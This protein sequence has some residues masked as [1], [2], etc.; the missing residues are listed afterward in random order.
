MATTNYYIEVFSEQTD[1]RRQH[2]SDAIGREISRLGLHRTISINLMDAPVDN[3]LAVGVYFGNSRIAND[4]QITGIVSRS[5]ALSRV[6]IPVVN[7]L[8]TY[9][10]SVPD[11]LR[12]INGFWWEGEGSSDRLC[13]KLLEELGVE[14]RQRRAFISH[15]RDDGLAAA[16]QLHDYLSH[17][18]FR[19][20]IDRFNIAPGRDVQ[21]EIADQLEDCA[22]LILLETPLAYTSDWV[23]DEV[24]YSLSHQLGMHIISWPDVEIRLPGTQGLPRQHLEASDL[25]AQKGYDIFT[26]TTLERIITA[27][28]AEH[29]RAMI[30]RRRYLLV[31][32]EEAAQDAGR[33]CLPL[34]GWRMVVMDQSSSSIVQVTP[35][36]PTVDDLYALDKVCG[37]YSDAQPGVLIHA[38]RRLPQFRRNVLAWAGEY[39]N[40]SL[41]PE[42]SIGAYW[43]PNVDHV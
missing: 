28:E 2:L 37:C 10:S 9:S 36:L 29:A 31:S 22:M 5:L 24:D 11:C 27:V 3:D 17:N 43:R 34:P 8:A 25:T 6:V 15:K 33:K 18:G 1:A 19:P 20:F 12:P 40:L 30:S 42:N 4:S 32:A 7:D 16:E 39:R 21:S 38:A 14:D 26:S 35:R 41:V 23:F 13:R